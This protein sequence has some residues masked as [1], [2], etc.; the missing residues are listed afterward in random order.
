MQTP[1]HGTPDDFL[2]E[3]ELS[4]SPCP[5]LLLRKKARK[6]KLEFEC[7]VD[8]SPQTPEIAMRI[9]QIMTQLETDKVIIKNQEDIFFFCMR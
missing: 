7:L 1:S 5:L 3:E 4:S 2:Y 6:S 8:A 9:T